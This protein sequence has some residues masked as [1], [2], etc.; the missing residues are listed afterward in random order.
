MG[1]KDT[2][3]VLRERDENVKAI[4][5]S[6]YSNDPIMSDY[7][8]FGFQ[9]VITK[10]YKVPELKKILDEVIGKKAT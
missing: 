9:G 7:R 8:A 6:G 4:V 5:C 2:I 1:G 10:P 3:K